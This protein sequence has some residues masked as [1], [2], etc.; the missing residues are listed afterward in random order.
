MTEP[1]PLRPAPP[2]VAAPRAAADAAADSIEALIERHEGPLL[3]FALSTARDRE[4]AEDAVQEA[5]LA[6]VRERRRGTVIDE[7]AAWLFRVVRNR[8]RDSQRREKRVR[9]RQTAVATPDRGRTE[10]DPLETEERTDTVA[11]LLDGLDTAT[12]EVLTLSVIEGKT[13]RQIAEL[14]GVSLATVSRRVHDGLDR[15]SGGLRAAGVL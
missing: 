10:A 4:V 2:R 8:V 12:R 3:R 6:L 15:I 5:F 14:T 9:E 1:L 7:P 13:Y 11:R